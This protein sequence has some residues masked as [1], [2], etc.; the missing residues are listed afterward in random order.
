MM[1]YFG[2]G[3]SLLMPMLI[4]LLTG[5]C[6]LTHAKVPTRPKLGGKPDR[7]GRPDIIYNPDV[8]KPLDPK[9]NVL[10]FGRDPKPG[11]TCNF[12]H[13]LLLTEKKEDW[14][15][16]T[17]QGGGTLKDVT[18]P[19]GA[20]LP[21]DKF[22]RKCEDPES[23]G[24]KCDFV[25]DKYGEPI[26]LI[27]DKDAT[28]Y[29]KDYILY[30]EDGTEEKLDT[31]PTETPIYYKKCYCPYTKLDTNTPP[32]PPMPLYFSEW[33]A[34]RNA[35]DPKCSSMPNSDTDLDKALKV[36][37]GDLDKKTNKAKC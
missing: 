27:D 34:E 28:F 2:K 29:I 31:E 20:Q 17:I 5:L 26:K 12:M 1:I 22:D 15:K 18:T 13:T 30:K 16:I 4:V 19:N 14:E 23:T 10:E 11:E 9:T 24:V 36:A 37:T 3:S 25:Y 8:Y 21:Y 6:L 7:K 35:Y 33:N 32:G